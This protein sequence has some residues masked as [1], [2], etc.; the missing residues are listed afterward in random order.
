VARAAA[1]AKIAAQR[2]RNN[3]NDEFDIVFNAAS[4]ISSGGVWPGDR[5]LYAQSI[6]RTTRRGYEREAM[7]F[8]D[9]AHR[10]QLPL[11]CGV[12]LDIALSLFARFMFDEGYGPSTG[13]RLV[14]AAKYVW[15][16]WSRDICVTPVCIIGWRKLRPSVKR[17]PLTRAVATAI[18]VR[19]IAWGYPS[20][21]IVTLLGFHCYLRI[22]EFTTTRC[23]DVVPA[24]S[25]RVG[26]GNPHMFVSIPNAKTGPLQDV[27]VLD[28]AIEAITLLCATV[29]GGGDSTNRLC[30]LSEYQY[31]KLFRAVC[32]SWQLPRDVTPHSLRHGGATHD[33]TVVG[34]NAKDIM[35]RGRWQREKSFAHYV[36]TM[37]AS[38]ALQKHPIH[39]VNTGAAL[40]TDLAASVASAI[41]IAHM[42]AEVMQFRATLRRSAEV[43]PTSNWK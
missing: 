18:A 23:V 15:P 11:T 16:M 38:V 7:R 14:A 1:K 37:R 24:A 25:E 33:H 34:R 2:R 29:M 17:I 20:A 12:D 6:A 32:D 4:A 21:G 22:G 10:E 27:E 42:N 41:A 39:V 5:M 19:M 36:G 26:L 35:I 9:F 13:E 31:R 3:T 30:L 43:F 40:T 8:I 28:S